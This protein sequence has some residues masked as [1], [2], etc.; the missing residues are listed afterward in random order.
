MNLK[1]TRKWLIIILLVSLIE[2]FNYFLLINFPPQGKAFLGY[3]SDEALV[4]GLMR[5]VEL[6][7]DNPWSPGEKIFFNGALTSP[8]VYIPLGYLRMLIGIDALLMNIIAKFILFFIF[9]VVLF[10]T[11]EILMPKKYKIAFIFFLLPLGIMPIGYL[12]GTVTGIERFMEG[13]S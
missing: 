10:K 9:L 7:F 5:S 4:S 13:F 11:M 1:I 6:N 3:D 8:Y 12:L 2:T